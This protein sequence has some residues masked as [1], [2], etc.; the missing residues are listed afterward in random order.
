MGLKT[1][2]LEVLR[3]GNKDKA[4]NMLKVKKTNKWEEIR[5]GVRC[6]KWIG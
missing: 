2:R 3:G 5:V 1:A 4:K 6:F